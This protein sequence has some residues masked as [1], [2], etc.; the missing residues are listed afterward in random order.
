MATDQALVDLLNLSVTLREL[1]R[2]SMG[3]TS[4]KADQAGVS[5]HVEYQRRQT[6]DR[7]GEKVIA[8]ST[9][10]F[11]D[12]ISFD[13]SDSDN[14]WVIL[15]NDLTFKVVSAEAI[16]DPRTGALHHWEMLCV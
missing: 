10:F 13:W 14:E 9:I 6:F 4:T 15:W 1:E 16:N 2:D 8:Q 3:N 7:A 12:S 11:D 5:A